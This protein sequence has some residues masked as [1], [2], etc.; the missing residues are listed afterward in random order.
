MRK[1]VIE[2]FIS[3]MRNEILKSLSTLDKGYG[4]R[5][6]AIS[7]ETG[8]PED[9]LTPILKRLKYDGKIELIMIWD[10]RTYK[11]DG[12]GYCLTDNNSY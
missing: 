9:I 6:F 8:I 11:P 12:S 3:D 7:I 4:K 10:E 2:S 5:K 1:T